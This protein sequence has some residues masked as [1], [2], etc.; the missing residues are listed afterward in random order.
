[1]FSYYT[2][3]AFSDAP[4]HPMSTVLRFSSAQNIAAT[5]FSPPTRRADSYGGTENTPPHTSRGP[6]TLDDL[7]DED[8]VILDM[9]LEDPEEEE[10]RELYNSI[11]GFDDFLETDDEG[12]HEPST[13]RQEVPCA[14]DLDG[15]GAYQYE[16]D[17]EDASSDDSDDAEVQPPALNDVDGCAEGDEADSE[18]FDAS[19]DSDTS[20]DISE[21]DAPELVTGGGSEVF[22]REEAD[23]EGDEEADNASEASSEESRSESSFRPGEKV[24]SERRTKSPCAALRQDTSRM[25]PVMT[26]TPSATVRRSSRLAQAIRAKRARAESDKSESEGS[27]HAPPKRARKIGIPAPTKR[28]AGKSTPRARQRAGL[29]GTCQ[30]SGSS[31]S[32]RQGARQKTE[33]KGQILEEVLERLLVVETEKKA[34]G[35][36]GCS[37]D[38]ILKETSACRR[39]MRDHHPENERKAPLVRCRWSGCQANV[40][41]SATSGGLT[42]HYDEAHLRYRYA[43]P[44]GCKTVKKG[45]EGVRTFARPDQI[46]R[47]ENLDPCEYLREYPIPRRSKKS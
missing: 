20:S 22:E 38:L 3:F 25:P 41:N 6:A 12:P 23:T 34:C 9:G 31:G 15:H 32:D 1:M 30:A 16:Q 8:R 14:E 36:P 44:G 27:R 33:R 4:L 42:R 43:C 45:A 39:H 19:C 5:A 46:T 17:D 35:V 11:P 24:V 47:H 2:S 26:A 10:Q 40:K 7:C 18:G 28:F 29:E 37:E 21:D 13:L